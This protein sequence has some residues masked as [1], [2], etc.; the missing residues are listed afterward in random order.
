M[1]TRF[2]VLLT[3]Y[4]S[5]YSLKYRASRDLCNAVQSPPHEKAFAMGITSLAGSIG[6]STAGAIAVPFHRY[7]CSLP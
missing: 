5:S 7:L 4:S 3:R 6:V 2:I 1:S